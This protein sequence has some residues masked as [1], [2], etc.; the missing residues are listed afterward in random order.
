VVG[1]EDEVDVERTP[2]P[3]LRLA[4]EELVEVALSG[5]EIGAGRNRLLTLAEAEEGGEDAWDTGG[6]GD[7]LI[8]VGTLVE[9]TMSGGAEGGNA[10]PERVHRRGVR[11]QGTE[12]G[13]H[14][15]RQVAVGAETFAEIVELR[16]IGETAVPEEKG[17]LLEGGLPGQLVD[18][19]ATIDEAAFFSEDV[20]EGGRGGDNSFEPL[21][22]RKGT[23]SVL[24]LGSV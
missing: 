19:V 24:R 8:E 5:V 13:E 7:R 2:V 22:F 23:V 3:G 15:L 21:R 14:R 18:V 10:G 6:E 17:D 16:A 11:G 1:E 12:G 9:E 4:V 20:A